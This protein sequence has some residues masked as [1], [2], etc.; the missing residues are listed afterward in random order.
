MGRFGASRSG[1]TRA[2]AGSDVYAPLGVPVRAIEA[3]EVVGLSSTYYRR[4]KAYPYVGAV[5]VE[6]E[7]GTLWRYA[8]TRTPNI[9]RVGDIVRP[10]QVVGHVGRLHIPGLSDMLHAER[11]LGVLPSGKRAT[12]SLTVSASASATHPGTKRPYLRRRDLADATALLTE[13][14]QARKAAEARPVLKR[15]ATGPDAFRLLTAL[16]RA[17]DLRAIPVPSFGPA[18]ETALRAWQ[19]RHGLT[20]DG[21]CG[22]DSW[23]LLAAHCLL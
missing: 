21:I 5:T 15:G 4:S 10:G 9:V 8:E 19:A 18:T 13:L 14:W 17:G 11:F 20:A 6:N 7:D 12:G 16:H 3:G 23:E 2:H 1:G 22:A